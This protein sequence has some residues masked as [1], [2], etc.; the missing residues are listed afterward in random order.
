MIAGDAFDAERLG[1]AATERVK[2]AERLRDAIVKA[3]SKI[4]ALLTPVQRGKLAYL[5]RTGALLI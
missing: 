2:S 5:I 4:H 1:Q 3:L